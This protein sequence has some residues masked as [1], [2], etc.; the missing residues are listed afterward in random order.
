MVI[1]SIHSANAL[2]IHYTTNDQ[3]IRNDEMVLIDAGS[4]YKSVKP[5]DMGEDLLY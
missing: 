2:T 5:F 1:N 4:E 3:I